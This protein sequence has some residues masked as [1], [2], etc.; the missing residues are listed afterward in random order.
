MELPIPNKVKMNIGDHAF[1]AEGS[2]ESVR[3]QF[4]I[5]Q[6]L[7]RLAATAPAKRRDELPPDTAS[8]MA[9]AKQDAP[10]NVDDNLTKIMRLENRV[11]SLT[12]QV[13]KVHDAVLVLLYGQKS[14]RANDAV[15]G[16]ELLSGLSATG[17]FAVGRLDRILDKLAEDGDVMAFGE[18]RGKRYRLTNTGVAKAR[19]IAQGMIATVA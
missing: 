11:V 10:I 16:S 18:R 15:T 4:Q 13:P 2:P 19:T 17:G 5:W 3:E 6:E 1:E 9:P 14:L 8:S 12:A 7:V